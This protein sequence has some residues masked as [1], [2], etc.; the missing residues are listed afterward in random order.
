MPG[1]DDVGVGMVLVGGAAKVDD[2]YGARFGEPLVAA[3]VSFPSL[4]DHL[5]KES[6]N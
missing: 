2:L 3:G 5:R 6:A 4:H 1:G